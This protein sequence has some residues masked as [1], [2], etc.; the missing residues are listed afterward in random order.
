MPTWPRSPR[1]ARRQTSPRRSGN[2]YLPGIIEKQGDEALTHQCVPL[3]SSLH[4]LEEFRR[5][6]EARRELLV[7]CSPNPDPCL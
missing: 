2:E 4:R 6:L 3:D 7:T 5:F 1:A